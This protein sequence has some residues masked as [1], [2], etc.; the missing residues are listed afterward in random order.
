MCQSYFQ[1]G[2]WENKPKTRL[3]TAIIYILNSTLSENYIKRWILSYF[4]LE[5]FKE[6]QNINAVVI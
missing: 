4:Y 5:Q 3:S 2:Q 6:L 1:P